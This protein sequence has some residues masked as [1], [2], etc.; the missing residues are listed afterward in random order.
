MGSAAWDEEIKLQYVT[1]RKK[2]RNFSECRKMK[3]FILNFV[4][5]GKTS[6]GKQLRI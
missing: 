6:G 2:T 3:W 1:E 4:V 5:R